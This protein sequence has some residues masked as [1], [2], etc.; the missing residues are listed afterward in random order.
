[1]QRIPGTGA[2]ITGVGKGTVLNTRR[3]ALLSGK[4]YYYADLVGGNLTFTPDPK[5]YII[6]VPPYMNIEKVY[7]FRDLQTESDFEAVYSEIYE[8]IN[9]A[10]QI[11]EQ[12]EYADF[13]PEAEKNQIHAE[14]FTARC[15]AHFMATLL[16]AQ[17]YNYTTDASH[18]GIVYNTRCQVAGVDYPAR[19]TMQKTWELLQQDME[20]ALSLF[21]EN[22]ALPYGPQHSYFN[23]CS[24]NALFARIALQMNDWEKA[25]QHAEYVIQHAPVNL[26]TGDRYIPEWEKPE[27]PVSEIL[28]EFSAPRDSEGS[29][30]SSLGHDF[31]SYSN[32]ITYNELVASGDLIDLYEAN[33]IRSGM[34]LIKKLPTSVNEVIADEP[35]YFTKKFQDDPGTTCIRLSE[36][37][38]IKAEAYARIGNN[39]EALA[40]LNTIRNRAGLASVTGTDNLLEEI[41]LERRRELAFEGHLFFDITRY[42]KDVI[43][44]KGCISAVCGLTWPSNYYVL[45]IPESSI[46]LNEN[47]T[48]NEGY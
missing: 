16:Y 34:F 26:M 2:R 3:C 15:M 9:E 18:L 20:T 24:A 17:N 32:L 46:T 41:F 35:Y 21:T 6:E 1:M 25:L 38:L 10:N 47:M 29:V 11:I 31:F 45:P 23:K 39:A 43:R 33:D 44:N 22:Q 4:F 7:E 14:A 12:I 8:L 27:E 19:Q 36:M 13:L 37:Y 42:K 5:D 40:A 30:S 28:L 48:Q